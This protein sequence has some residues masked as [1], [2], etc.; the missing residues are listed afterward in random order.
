MPIS[1]SHVDYFTRNI[2][3]LISGPL[4]AGTGEDLLASMRRANNADEWTWPTG[5]DLRRFA[6]LDGHPEITGSDASNPDAVEI[7]VAAAVSMIAR[8]KGLPVLAEDEDGNVDPSGT[9]PAIGADTFLATLL[10]AHKLYRLGLAPDGSWGFGDEASSTLMAFDPV[11]YA[12]L[13]E[14]PSL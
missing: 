3:T 13:W 5:D 11:V 14:P 7:A 4:T 12:L 8:Q 6:E 2:G 1:W 9:S 10:H